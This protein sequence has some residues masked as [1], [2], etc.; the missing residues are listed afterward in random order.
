MPL[1]G[2]D[3][4]D[5]LLE[6][7][8]RLELLLGGPGVRREL[9]ARGVDLR[10]EVPLLDRILRQPGAQHGRAFV[11]VVQPP[12]PLQLLGHHDSPPT[13]RGRPEGRPRT[14]ARPAA[15]AARRSG[16]AMRVGTGAAPRSPAER[17]IHSLLAAV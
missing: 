15:R 7:A 4:F 6:L 8:P 10:F 3:G 5:L 14:S 11:E 17:D 16:A 1:L 13:D 2:G 9:L 12:Q